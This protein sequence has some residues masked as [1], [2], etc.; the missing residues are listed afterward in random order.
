[1]SRAAWSCAECDTNNNA[2]NDVCR[3]CAAAREAAG[4]AVREQPVRQIRQTAE[5]PVFVESRYAT[6][7]PAPVRLAGTGPVYRPAPPPPPVHTV[8]HPPLPRPMPPAPR[9]MPPMPRPVPPMP[10]S[11]PYRRP[12]RRRGTGRV[13]K[14]T[15]I[16][17]AGLFLLGNLD[18][19]TDLL[20]GIGTSTEQP[21]TACP[22]EVAQW[23]PD[24]GSGAVL[25]AAYTT[26]KHVITLC[27]AADGTLHYDG[28]YLDLPVDENTHMSIDATPTANGYIAHHG[29][30]TY[31]ISG[32]EVIIYEGDVE[33]NRF[34]LTR[35][36]P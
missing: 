19:L 35:T 1:M 5:Q 12:Y 33:K 15:L 36:G 34:P 27:R 13:L 28:R 23:L 32:A 11:A 4:G 9:P 29:T 25:E 22:P 30:F 7:P 18:K 2:S 20:S 16:V 31:E 10:G 3:N 8:P 24:G 26:P 6:P 17:V 14:W 21:A